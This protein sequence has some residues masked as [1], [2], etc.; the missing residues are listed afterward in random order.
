MSGHHFVCNMHLH[1][2]PGDAMHSPAAGF[3]LLRWS[4]VSGSNMQIR[5]AVH[6]QKAREK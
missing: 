2:Q 5:V 1:K 6:Q 3:M 4:I